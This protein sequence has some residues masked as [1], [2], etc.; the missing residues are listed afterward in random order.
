MLSLTGFST[1]WIPHVSV[2]TWK[3]QMMSLLIMINTNGIRPHLS[4]FLFQHLSQ[5]VHRI[6]VMVC[7]IW[8]T[9]LHFQLGFAMDRGAMPLTMGRL[10]L[11]FQWSTMLNMDLMA[12]PKAYLQ[13]LGLVLLW[14]RLHLYLLIAGHCLLLS[15]IRGVNTTIQFLCTSVKG[16]YQWVGGH[17][18]YF[19]AWWYW[20]Y[21]LVFLSRGELCSCFYS[22]KYN[23]PM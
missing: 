11:G 13:L 18:G 1:F 23:F 6:M 19:C 4:C 7:L 21:F 22:W 16:L 17:G 10:P 12:S 15:C 9:L 2:W 5:G 3:A 20:A 14:C 8:H